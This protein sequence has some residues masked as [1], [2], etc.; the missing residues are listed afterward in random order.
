MY[1]ALVS[2]ALCLVYIGLFFLF[3]AFFGQKMVRFPLRS[4]YSI[5][6]IVFFSGVVFAISLAIPNAETS[7]RIMHIFG[8]GFISYLIC[9]L[10]VLDSKTRVGKFQFFVFSF[11]LVIALGV[12]N[13]ILEYFLQ[14][15]T[16][17]SF[18]KTAND[19]WLDL[20]SNCAGALIAAVLFTPFVS[21]P[22]EEK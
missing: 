11:L 15:Y 7:N 19:T 1:L 21:V 10:A 4:F 17:F 22:V 8:G 12:G 18:A 14:N 6:L 2:F 3:P 13:E 20:I 9:F 5:A 16:M